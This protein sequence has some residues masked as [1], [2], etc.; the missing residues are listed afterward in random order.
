MGPE[1]GEVGVR[2]AESRKLKA[3]IRDYGLRDHGLGE[4]AEN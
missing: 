3:D 1:K 2:K 4:N